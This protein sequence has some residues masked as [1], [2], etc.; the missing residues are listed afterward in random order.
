MPRKVEH[1]DVSRLTVEYV[2]G[3]SAQTI[4]ERYDASRS[5]ILGRLHAAGVRVRRPTESRVKVIGLD[6]RYTQDFLGLLDGILLGDG[7]IVPSGSLRIEQSAERVGWL[8]DVQEA[9]LEFD[10]ASKIE[11]IRRAPR[12]S[13]DRVMPAWNGFML[14][15]PSY[16]ELKE[17]RKRWYPRGV[18]QVPADCRMSEETLR[19]WICGDGS[20]RPDGTFVLCTDGFSRR[21]VVRLVQLLNESFSL[22]AR[23]YRNGSRWKIGLFR[24]DQV[25]A[26]RDQLDL[27]K[28][29]IYKFRYARAAQRRGALTEADVREIR[30]ARGVKLSVLAERYNLSRSAVNNVALRKTYRWVQ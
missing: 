13:K 2:A 15:T 6:V 11:P 1:L 29:C 8:S 9:F 7:C 28:C 30:A 24:K 17:Q 16:A 12:T 22:R 3:A 5:T 26:L 18:K 14:R 27:P 20:G 21:E 23:P 19:A 4:A 10:V 25:L